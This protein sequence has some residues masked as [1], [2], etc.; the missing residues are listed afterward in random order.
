MKNRGCPTISEGV[1]EAARPAVNELSITRKLV[2]NREEKSGGEPMV[3]RVKPG[4]TKDGR[5]KGRLDPSSDRLKG[6]GCS[7]GN[8]QEA[9]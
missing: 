9:G 6:G 8:R 1:E 3:T 5:E 2:P 7:G 4:R